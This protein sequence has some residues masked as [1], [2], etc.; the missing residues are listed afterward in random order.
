VNRDSLQFFAPCP[1]GLEHVCAHELTELGAAGV[2]ATN[3]GV[4]VVGSFDLCYRINLESRIASRVLWQIAHCGY[5][6]ERDVYEAAR[7]I[8]W[9][10]YFDVSRT[11]RVNVAATNSP[12]K[13]LDFI[14]LRIK[15]AVCDAF[16]DATGR[17]PSVDTTAPDVRIHA[18]FD[19]RAVRIYLD[20]S[21]EALFKRGL[22]AKGMQAPLR[23]NLAAGILRLAEWR[24]SLPLL[25]P[26][27]GA[28]TFLLEAAEI[29]L[30]R[31]A[32]ARRSFGF[33]K[34][35]MFDRNQWSAMLEQARGRER[36]AQDCGIH[37]SDL[38]G[39]VLKVA[40][41]NLTHAGLESAVS[42]KQA[43][44]LELSPPASNGVL[45]T[46]PPY[47]VRLGEETELAQFY[48]KLGDALKRRFA[49]WRACIFTADMRLPKLIGLKPRRRTPL[50]NGALECRLYEF[51]LIAGAMRRRKA[52][53]E[54]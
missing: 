4:S 49:G 21:G 26:M 33:E 11:L 34:L 25:D 3:G 41:E 16:R 2:K 24:P 6:N 35:N 45:V 51:E 5:R 38:Y 23:E 53:E 10:D 1:R 31:A 39:E 36:P 17:R 8:A 46:N 20:T 15:D 54:G 29:A 19:E 22:R 42:L 48:P 27:C 18:Y 32:G 47:G 13:S 40:R 52:G 30:D 43:N 37:G 7:A 12:L 28:G 44:V 9:P 14:T 50:F